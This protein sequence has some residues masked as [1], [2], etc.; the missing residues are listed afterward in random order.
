M[1]PTGAGQEG[2]GVAAQ[3]SALTRQ[4]RGVHPEAA[5]P[6]PDGTTVP[7]SLAVSSKGH[8]PASYTSTVW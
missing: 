7:F 4:G 8:R 6:H 5:L 2:H 1:M 3:M